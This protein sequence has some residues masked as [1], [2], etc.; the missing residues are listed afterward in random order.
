MAETSS[1][2]LKLLSLLQVPR[3]WPG[4]ELAARLEVSERTVR[5][6]VDRL[7]ELGYRI[8]AGKGPHSGYRLEAGSAL[9]PLLFDDEQAVALTVVLKTVTGAGLEE[10]AARTLATIRQVLPSR[11][12]HRVD[13]LQVT[14]VPSRPE[15]AG[16][17]VGPDELVAL[18]A[19]VRAREELRFDY[20][21]H[22][23]ETRRRTQPHHIVTWGGRWYLI[24]WDLDRHDWRVFRVDRIAPRSPNG[25]R[26]TPRELPGG[27]VQDFVRARFK[28][29]DGPDVWPCTGAAVLAMPAAVA[30]PFVGDAVVEDLGSERCR[31]TL[32]SWSWAALATA[33][34]RFDADIESVHPPELASTFARLAD[35]FAAAADSSR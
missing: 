24:A 14:A 11:L 17:P 33:I 3:G 31:L 5:R 20:A 4:G 10:A 28:G 29:S 30:A 34:G 13:T 18:G 27:D 32:G 26:F 35:R 9:P 15:P 7:R 6:D 21:A 12:R 16:P 2:M 19:A 25:P 22:G 1:R 23:E 8:H